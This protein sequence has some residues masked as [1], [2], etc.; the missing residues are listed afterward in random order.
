MPSQSQPLSK[1]DLQRNYYMEDEL[2]KEFGS[3]RFDFGGNLSIIDKLNQESGL[4]DDDY[5][6]N[7]RGS[8]MSGY[9]STGID[10]GAPINAKRPATVMEAIPEAKDE[11]NSKLGIEKK[12]LNDYSPTH[13]H[14]PQTYP[15]A[16]THPQISISPKPLVAYPSEP[17]NLYHSG[18]SG[19]ATIYNYIQ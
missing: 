3:N 5:F 16:P 7:G 19:G 12:S 18:G 15:I 13:Q 9:M 1:E 11:E 14:V 10:Y 6:V 2:E 4:F 8:T 17:A